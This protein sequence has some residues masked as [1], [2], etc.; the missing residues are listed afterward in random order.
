MF[1]V[2][3]NN[4]SNNFVEKNLNYIQ[5]VNSEQL[6]TSIHTMNFESEK[7]LQE[8]NKY[9]K[10]HAIDDWQYIQELSSRS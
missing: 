6:Y 4:T 9:I 1:K 8:N 3:L 2:I 10:D 5:N 7:V